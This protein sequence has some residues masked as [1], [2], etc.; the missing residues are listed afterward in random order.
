M[1][2][3]IYQ[4]H[5]GEWRWRLKA[6]NGRIL[7]DSAEGY[8]QKAKCWKA[9]TSIHRNFTTKLVPIKEIM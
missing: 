4:N 5:Q 1:R 9:I 6:R 2:I 8:Q 7:A 3:E